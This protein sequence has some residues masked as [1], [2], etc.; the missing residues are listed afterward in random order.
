MIFFLYSGWH[1]VTLPLPLAALQQEYI[2]FRMST[3]ASVIPTYSWAID[4]GS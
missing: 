4:Q 2:R 3:P 1:R